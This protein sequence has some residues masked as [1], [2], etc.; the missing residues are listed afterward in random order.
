MAGR[1]KKTAD[2]PKVETEVKASTTKKSVENK[3]ASNL[4]AIM[5]QMEEMQKQILSL[6]KENESL[7]NDNSSTFVDIDADMDVEIVSQFRG[8]LVLATEPSGHGTTYIFEHFGEV[9]DIPFSDVKAI[10]KNMR[11]FA[12]EGL[13]YILDRDVVKKLRLGK[14]YEKMLGFDDMST[15]EKKSSE[16]VLRLFNLASD[17]QQEEIISFYLEKYRNKETVDMN[18][19][20]GLSNI[21]GRNLLED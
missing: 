14:K 19:L 9:Q 5:K 3:E 20:Q 2:A 6:Q 15:L 13:F 4:E 1:P 21:I 16:E 17:L 11:S 10:C 18:V 12:E 8:T 7:Q